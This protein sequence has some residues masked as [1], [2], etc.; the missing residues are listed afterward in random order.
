MVA[1]KVLPDECD[2]FPEPDLLEGYDVRL[3]LFREKD[4]ALEPLFA[5][6]RE[7]RGQHPH[8]EVQDFEFHE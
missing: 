7:R 4:E 3:G 6:Y 5:V 2:V 1:R 8:V